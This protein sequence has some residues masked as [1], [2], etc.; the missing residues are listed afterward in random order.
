MKQIHKD[1]TASTGT[2]SKKCSLCNDVGF[3]A[4]ADEKGVIR[5]GV[6]A[7]KIKEQNKARLGINIGFQSKTLDNY[8]VT[9]TIQGEMK[10]KASQYIQGFNNNSFCLLGQVGAGKTHIATSIANALI[11][12][13][14]NVRY[15]LFNNLIEDYIRADDMQLK[16]LDDKYKQVQVLL[17]DDLF[18]TSITSWNGVKKL[19]SKHLEIM[20]DLINYR[21][22]NKKAVIITCEMLVNEL[23]ELDEATTSR[24]LE[25]SRGYVVQIQKDVKMNYRIWGTD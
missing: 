12:K 7:C 8:K 19:N 23:L 9:N 20:F 11:D 22:L 10:T 2:S 17:I 25:M 14:V 5:Y 16:V 3:M 6:C 4:K 18:K 15:V 1:T 13:N 24:L 21:Y